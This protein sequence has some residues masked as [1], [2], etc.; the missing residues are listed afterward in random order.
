MFIFLIFRSLPKSFN[1]DSI[2]S[3]AI[4]KPLLVVNTHTCTWTNDEIKK[5]FSHLTHLKFHLKPCSSPGSRI[6]NLFNV[7]RCFELKEKNEKSFKERDEN[8]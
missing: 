5:H 6:G 4:L 1:H 7:S 2:Y 3:Q 8:L